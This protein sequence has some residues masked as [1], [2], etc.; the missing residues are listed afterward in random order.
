MCL[1]GVTFVHDELIPAQLD[2]ARTHRERERER[3]REKE[4]ERAT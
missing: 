2:V 4:S 3:E 1:K